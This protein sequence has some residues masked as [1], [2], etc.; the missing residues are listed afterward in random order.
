MSNILISSGR[1][2]FRRILQRIS[3]LSVATAMIACWLFL[4]IASVLTLKQYAQQN[5]QL[6]GVTVSHSLE[7]AVAFRDVGEIHETLTALGRQ[8]QFSSALVRDSEGRPIARWPTT[9][10]PRPKTPDALIQRWLLPDPVVQTVWY[11]GVPVGEVQLTAKGRLITHFIWLSLALL[12]GFLILAS[13]L[14]LAI[15]HYFHRGLVQALQN[16]TE[17]V[18]DV[19]QNRHFSRRVKPEP[20]EEFQRFAHDFNCLLDE[21]EQWQ[22]QQQRHSAS[23]RKSALHDPLTG[24][25]NRAAFREALEKVLTDPLQRTHHAL[26]FMDSD[27]FKQI[28]DNWGHAAGDRALREIASR[29]LRFSARRYP[30][31]RLGGDEF[32][33]LISDVTIDEQ[34]QRLI[35]RLGYL[36]V[37]PMPLRNGE[38]I[39]LSL[40]VGY[41]L[42]EPDSTSE[43][44]LEIADSSMYHNKKLRRGR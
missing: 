42:V 15:S 28:N 44:L 19:R 12:T 25:A 35:S 40:S 9:P 43:S 16:I 3:I 33:M 18:H 24:L 4:S 31:F 22:K 26:L 7:A 6:L 37:P 34:I 38:A 23:L 5:M 30:T 2:T 41:A 20:I 29:L 32:A 13:A 1:P 27:N 11:D 8:Q 21:M 36:F 39:S 14:S 17:V 10:R